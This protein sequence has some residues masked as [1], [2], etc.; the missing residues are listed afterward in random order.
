V[1]DRAALLLRI[2]GD[3]QLLG[4]VSGLFISESGKLLGGIREAIAARDAEGFGRA[5]HTMRG[6]LRSLSANA[7]DELARTLQSLDVR[8]DRVQAESVCARLERAI[9]VLKAR[10]HAL[11]AEADS[12]APTWPARPA[13]VA[14]AVA[15]GAP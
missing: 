11:A 2:D 1:I 14:D 6:M 15:Q 7:A 12:M 9:D 10:L 3:A 8:A 4:E 5:V 13:R